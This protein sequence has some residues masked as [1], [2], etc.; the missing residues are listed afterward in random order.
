MKKKYAI[1]TLSLLLVVASTILLINKSS[2]ALVVPG[3]NYCPTNV[4]ANTSSN[5][6]TLIEYQNTKITLPKIELTVDGEKI[7]NAVIKIDNNTNITNQRYIK[8][9][10]S[11]TPLPTFSNNQ[12]ENTY[13]TQLFMWYISDL[14]ENSNNL[15]TAEKEAIENSTNGKKIITAIE[16]YEKYGNWISSVEGLPVLTLD[17]IDTSKITYYATN[18]YIETNLITPEAPEDYAYVF[19]NYTVEVTSPITVVDENGNE[20]TDFQKGEGFK[21]RIPLS[22]I[23]NNEIKFEAK[24]I[25]R[26]EFKIWG[27]Y[28]IAKPKSATSRRL[29]SPT[30]FVDCGKTRTAETF[31]TLNLNY[32]QQVG[33]LKIQVIDAE[34]KENL[35][36]AE[37]VIYDQ[38][39]NI[40][41]R[42]ETTGSEL[43]ITLPVGEYTVRQ[44]VTP[45]NYEARVVEQK[46]SITQNRE[47]DAILENIQLIEVP[48]TSKTATTISVI[49]GLIILVG[50]IMIIMSI[51]RKT[52]NRPSPSNKN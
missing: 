13:Y 25:G 8:Q 36:N 2:Y 33:T 18:D 30:L 12:D 28:V 47:T 7:N 49:G 16:E 19:T 42:Y 20:K 14:Y 38:S 6:L 3:T 9:R 45:P 50:G 15:T 35:S 41:Y 40:V 39:G 5:S 24:I 26:G 27:E 29:V 34:T 31:E 48:D 23:K 52:K 17:N 37:V 32:T 11:V 4:V 10:E 51:M 44:T 21:L 46:I 43:N 22:E 1:I